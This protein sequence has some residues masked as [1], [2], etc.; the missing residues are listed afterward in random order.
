MMKRCSILLA[1]L[2]LALVPLAGTAVASH[3]PHRITVNMVDFKFALSKAA[4]PPGTA[5]FNVMNHG[6]VIHDFKIAGK[7]TPIYMNGKGGV[8]RVTFTKS[9]RYKYV[10]TVPGHVAAGMWGVLRVR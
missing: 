5:V 10:C 2:G 3:P 1:F 4:V 8:L 9:G 7:K 6:K